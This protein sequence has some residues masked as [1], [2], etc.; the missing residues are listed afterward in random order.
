[1]YEI[2]KEDVIYNN[3]LNKLLTVIPDEK[4]YFNK[5][6]TELNELILT[7]LFPNI[8]ELIYR[9]IKL[10]NILQNER[11]Y[12]INN[13]YEVLYREKWE[14]EKD[15]NYYITLYTLI[16]V[17]L[18]SNIL[19][20]IPLLYRKTNNKKKYI[21]WDEK[22][23][24]QFYFRFGYPWYKCVNPKYYNII[25]YSHY[26]EYLC[27][28]DIKNI[29]LAFLL[30]GFEYDFDIYNKYKFKFYALKNKNINKKKLIKFQNDNNIMN[31]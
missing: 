15:Y 23:N 25:K 8:R 28:F 5:L 7:F 27:Y 18:I 3:M 1:M 11:K 21:S 9:I 22:N 30:Y 31:D 16:D 19:L 12:V 29:I 26:I 14:Y 24:F 2:N 4:S 13:L 6:P 17:E 20:V 10:N